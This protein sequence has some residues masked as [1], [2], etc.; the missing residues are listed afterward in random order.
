MRYFRQLFSPLADN[1]LQVWF[2]HSVNG[3][4]HDNQHSP[5]SLGRDKKNISVKLSGKVRGHRPT[6]MSTGYKQL[7]TNYNKENGKS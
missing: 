7:H 2:A 1:F 5:L 3:T 6:L 4:S